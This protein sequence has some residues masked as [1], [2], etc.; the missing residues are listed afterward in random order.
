MSLPDL[1]D[2]SERSHVGDRVHLPPS[3][4]AFQL[5]GPAFG[6]ADP[7]PGDQV[8]NRARHEHLS[9]AGESGDPRADVHRDAS[10]VVAGHLDLSFIQF[11][12]VHELQQ[13]GKLRVLAVATDKRIEA[14]PDVPT[15]AEAGYP[16]IVSETWNAIS[17]PPKT[18]GPIILKLN[19]SINEALQEADVLA[20]LRELQVLVGGGD[21][22]QTRK[23]V[24]EQRALWGK[25]IQAAS[26]PQQ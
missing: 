18:P 19:A 23:F 26:V 11:S 10:H 21:A 17:A 5:E 14:L 8:S 3:G 24:Q 1:A 22:T 4:Y 15:M 2:R 6:E 20:R 12:A 7:G 25:V 13:S 9:R 16:D